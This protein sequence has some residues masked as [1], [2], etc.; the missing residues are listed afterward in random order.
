MTSDDERQLRRDLHEIAEL[1]RQFKP[2]YIPTRYLQIL[3]T[4]IQS[5]WSG[6]T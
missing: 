3:R 5:S 2:P 1:T 6:A 4:V